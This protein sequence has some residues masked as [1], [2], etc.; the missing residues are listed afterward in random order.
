MIGQKGNLWGKK[1]ELGF[2]L[3]QSKLPDLK[4]EFVPY[5]LP[6][7]KQR[8]KVTFCVKMEFD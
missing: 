8:P 2:L 7:F 6:T 1:S 3:E 5:R 4:S